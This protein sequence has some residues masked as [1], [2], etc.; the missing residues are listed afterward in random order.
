MTRRGR[1]ECRHCGQLFRTGP[2][3]VHDRRYYSA[4][5][6]RR[7]SK[8]ASRRGRSG[9]S[10]IAFISVLVSQPIGCGVAF[11][12]AIARILALHSRWSGSR[13]A[14]THAKVQVAVRRWFRVCTEQ[15]RASSG[16]GRSTLRRPTGW[17]DR[18]PSMKSAGCEARREPW[19]PS[20]CAI[21]VPAAGQREP[22]P[23][24]ASIDARRAAYRAG[25]WRL[26]SQLAPQP[27]RV[28]GPVR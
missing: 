27:R 11:F 1:R 22:Q 19:P 12:K 25:A 20:R 7:A 3:N 23:G 9:T 18:A 6:C 24:A 2:R 5:P 10:R 4:R 16:Q 13:P 26:Y 8:A 15:P 17:Q 28:V 21:S 14:T